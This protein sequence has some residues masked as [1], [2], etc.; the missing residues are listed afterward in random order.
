MAAS[1]FDR[2]LR[3]LFLLSRCGTA[4]FSDGYANGTM[5][6][7]LTILTRIYGKDALAAGDHS[8]IITSIGFAGTVVGMLSFGF[9]SDKVGRKFGMV[10]ASWIV[11]VFSALSAV[12]SGRNGSLQGLLGMLSACRFLL[13]IGV[14][15]EY[16]S[17]SVAASEQSE[18]RAIQKNAHH[19][20]LT[21]ATNS[22]I[23]IGITFSAFIPLIL[24]WIFGANHLRAV[25][26]ISLGLGVIPAL[27]IFC[28]RYAIDEPLLYK[29]DSIRGST[30]YLLILRRYG[31]RLAAISF[32]WFLYD[33]ITYP[34]G[35]FSSTIVNNI[36]GGNEALSVVLGWNV[37]INLFFVPGTV[38]GAFVM[39][40][41]GPRTLGYYHYQYYSQ[42]L[43]IPPDGW[44][45]YTSCYWVH[46]EQFVQA[47]NESYCSV[48]GDL[49]RLPQ[50]WRTWSWQ[51]HFC[52]SQQKLPNRH[53][54]SILWRCGSC[55]KS[56][57]VLG[58]LGAPPMIEAFGGP[59]S[60]RGNTGP[61]WIGSALALL[62]A[63]VT[64]LFIKPL[65]HDGMVK[66]D[67]LFRQY[68]E[69]NGYDTSNMGMHEDEHDEVYPLE[70][71]ETA[72]VF[73]TSGEPRQCA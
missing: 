49:W 47:V 51:L 17:G 7:V 41:L 59:D 72:Q 6:G 11:V 58:Y 8:R 39:D 30:P 69:A 54:R 35:L 19:R 26:R 25:W 48:C 61:F 42:T 15:A 73:D 65:D 32:V 34:F 20:W 53:Q 40:Y 63:V 43:T 3:P 68:L 52:L 13:G 4:L 71:K 57:S 38:G 14:G 37:V 22:M 36:T 29:N 9:L 33:F 23:D 16:P 46:Y 70:D 31:V 1:G 12:S 56:W 28:W 2:P 60:A 50:S 5:G 55:W 67:K 62:S 24:L 27:A 45:S 44:T 64:F 18:E 10:A 66:E 21:L